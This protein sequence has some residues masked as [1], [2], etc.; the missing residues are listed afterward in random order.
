[1]EFFPPS[2]SFSKIIERER[3]PSNAATPLLIQRHLP[4]FFSSFRFHLSQSSS[5]MSAVDLA[6]IALEEVALEG[7][8]GA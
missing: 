2:V 8:A 7:R 5:A 1:L 3:A 4:R 6:L